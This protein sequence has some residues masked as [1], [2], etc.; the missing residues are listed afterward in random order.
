ME[1]VNKEFLTTEQSIAELGISKSL[2]FQLKAKNNLPSYTID[3]S[4]GKKNLFKRSDILNMV[5]RKHK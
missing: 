3:G 2:F 5:V 4:S 1:T